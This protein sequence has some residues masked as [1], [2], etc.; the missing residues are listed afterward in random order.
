[1]LNQN[2]KISVRFWMI[3]VS[4][5]W[6]KNIFPQI[7]FSTFYRVTIYQ[8]VY[9]FIFSNWTNRKLVGKIARTVWESLSLSRVC[10]VRWHY[11]WNLVLGISLLETVQE[12]SKVSKDDRLTSANC[13]R[14]YCKYRAENNSFIGQWLTT[15]QPRTPRNSPKHYPAKD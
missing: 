7:S 6:M 12:L 14:W 1:M 11:L 13:R 10:L 9:L 8:Y 2:L 15:G 4:L 3:F 5:C